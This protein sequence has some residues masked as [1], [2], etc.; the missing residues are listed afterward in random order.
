MKKLFDE[1]SYEVSKC[2]TRKYSTSFSLGILALK[3]SIRSAIYAIYGY[4]RL[5]DEIVDSFH[6]YNKEK[7]LSRLKKETYNAIEEG[8]SLN[9]ILQAFQQTV[10]D[11]RIDRELI[12]T[13][14]H[15]MEMDLQ[16]I[17]FDSK[18]YNEYI[19]G[20]AEV[21]GLMCLQ[22]FTEGNKEKFEELKPYAMKLGSAFQ[23]INFL[24]D[25]KDDY[26]ILGR[27]YFP[28]INMSVFDNSV[29]FKIEDEIETEFKQAL[30][31]IKKLPGSSMFG[32]YLAYRY[33]LSL[34]YKIKKTSSQRI[35]QNRIRIANSQKLLLACESYIRYKVA[36]L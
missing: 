10:H 2:T 3:P 11:Y 17:D 1:L 29:K 28:D 4:V 5:A 33:Y 34:F 35:M 23:K 7:L 14:L 19:Y 30:I 20:S 22:V 27:T 6:D 36:Y 8:I 18:L 26:Q 32:V 16:K 31:G 13:F 9:P 24:R 12:D 15:S 25:L 21:V